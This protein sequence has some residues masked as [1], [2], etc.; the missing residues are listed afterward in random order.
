M[1]NMVNLEATLKMVLRFLPIKMDV[2]VVSAKHGHDVLLVI[3]DA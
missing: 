3:Y 2:V 1:T